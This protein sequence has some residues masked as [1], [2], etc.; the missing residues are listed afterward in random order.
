[1]LSWTFN[2]M[3]TIIYSYYCLKCGVSFTTGSRLKRC[4]IC[5]KGKVKQIMPRRI[6]KERR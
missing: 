2:N 4:L 6:S 1:M 3:E 5:K